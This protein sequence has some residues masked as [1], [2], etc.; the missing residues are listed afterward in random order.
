MMAPVLA[1]AVVGLV[2]ILAVALIVAALVFYLV[3]VIV[4]L[5]K[6]TAGL[7]EAIAGVT[8]IVQK[9]TPVNDIVTGVVTG[10]TRLY[11]SY[12]A[13][14]VSSLIGI[15]PEIAELSAIA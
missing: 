3:S 12:A 11:Q 7:D 1:V 10:I 14:V 5:R 8:E 15:D 9:S 2:T 6:I 4:Q 13:D